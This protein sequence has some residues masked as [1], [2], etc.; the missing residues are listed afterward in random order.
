MRPERW[1]ASHQGEL[2]KNIEKNVTSTIESRNPDSVKY[3]KNTPK[4]VFLPN[5]LKASMK[6]VN[7]QAQQKHSEPDQT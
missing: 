1:C 7:L 2:I 6:K 3:K 4:V 5:F